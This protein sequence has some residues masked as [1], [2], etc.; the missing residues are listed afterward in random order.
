[1]SSSVSMFSFLLKDI[2]FF[3]NTPIKQNGTNAK[4]PSCPK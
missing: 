2:T 1:M 3:Q 4:L